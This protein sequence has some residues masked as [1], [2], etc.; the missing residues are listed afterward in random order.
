M[1]LWIQKMLASV[2]GGGKIGG[3][4]VMTAAFAG[5]GLGAA[6]GGLGGC[7]LGAQYGT[8]IWTAIRAA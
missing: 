7:I 5:C 6:V 8:A 3:G 4:E 2:E 1:K